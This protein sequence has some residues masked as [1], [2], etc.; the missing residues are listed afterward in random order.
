MSHLFYKQDN[1]I[2]PSIIF[3]HFGDDPPTGYSLITEA[4]MIKDLHVKRFERLQKDGIDYSF[5]YIAQIYMDTV[6]QDIT[7]Q[8]SFDFWHHTFFIFTQLRDGQWELAQNTNTNLNLS[9][10]YDQTRKDLIQVDL[11]KYVDNN[12]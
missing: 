3:L 8:E 4:S 6:N 12:Y 2:A 10:I 11:D 5:S 1:V 9:G 7:K